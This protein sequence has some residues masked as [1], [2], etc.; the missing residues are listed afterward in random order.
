MQRRGR[1][2]LTDTYPRTMD[3]TMGANYSPRERYWGGMQTAPASRIDGFDSN[4]RKL[5][6]SQPPSA[7]KS[8]RRR[9]NLPPN[10]GLK[11]GSSKKK[12][13][14]WRSKPALWRKAEDGDLGPG[15]GNSQP[16]R[17]SS[18][19]QVGSANSGSRQNQASRPQAP[20]PGIRYEQVTI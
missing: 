17:L 11:I 12:Q 1:S 16:N 18:G 4:A 9:S 13:K 15:A 20:P 7:T 14:S 19:F 3:R 10:E 8:E 6:R 5:S 2:P